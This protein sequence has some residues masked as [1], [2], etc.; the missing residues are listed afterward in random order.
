MG[1]RELEELL[2]RLVTLVQTDT[3]APLAHLGPQELHCLALFLGRLDHLDFLVALVSQVAKVSQAFLGLREGQ[4]L[5]D[6]R[7]REEIPALVDNLDPKV[8]LDQEVIQGFQVP[9]ARDSQEPRGRTAFLDSQVL[10][11]SLEKCTEPPLEPQVQMAS[12][13]NQGTKAFQGI[14]DSQEHQVGMEYLVFQ[15]QREREDWM[16][17]LVP[18]VSLVYLE[19]FHLREYVDHKGLLEALGCLDPQDFQGRKVSL[20]FPGPL[21]LLA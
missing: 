10:R 16:D 18:L 13:E 14:A 20:V 12:L 8:L 21:G 15:D 5:M 2:E 7:V 11:E 4:D 19:R 6:P 1:T 3:L 17:T 9:Q